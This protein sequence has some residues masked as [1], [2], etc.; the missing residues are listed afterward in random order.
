LKALLARILAKMN[1]VLLPFL[2]K[3]GIW[4]IGALALLDSST[5]PVPMDAFLAISDLER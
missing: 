3:F 4:G 5:I 1:L 2:A